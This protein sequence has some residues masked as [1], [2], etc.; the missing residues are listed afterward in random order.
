M[1][2][3]ITLAVGVLLGVALPL[4][5]GFLIPPASIRDD[6]VAPSG[7]DEALLGPT[8]NPYNF[9]KTEKSPDGTTFR[10]TGTHATTT[11]PYAA[12]LGRNIAVSL[13]L[14]A[15]REPGQPPADVTLSLNGRPAAQFRAAQDFQVYTA[16]IDD[17]A[18]PNPALDPAH[19][20]I[21]IESTTFV[22]LRKQRD[23]GVAVDWIE[24]RPE[25]SL[26]QVVVEA[27]VWGLSIL[28]VLCVAGARLGNRWGAGAGLGLLATLLAMHLTYVP[29]GTSP[30]VESGLVGL[31]WL[32]GVWLAPRARPVWGLVPALL[33]LWLVA[34]GR[35]LGEWQ[36]DDA[37]ISY[38]YGW[39]LVHGNGLIYNP[40]ERVEGYTN[41]LWTLLSAASLRL[42]LVPSTVALT[43][44]IALSL[45]LVALTWRLGVRLS[46]RRY[47]WPAT[48]CS[49]LVIDTAI[50]SYGARGSGMES[51]LFAFLVM[52]AADLIYSENPARKESYILGGLAL[53]LATLTRPE[54]WLV[55]GL[56]IGVRLLQ[57]WKGKEAW[58]QATLYTLLPFLVVVLPYEVW[59]ISYYGFLFPNT[60]YA[61]TGASLALVRRGMEHFSF[62][63]GD[64]W[65]P[66]ALTVLGIVMCILRWRRSSVLA[67]LGAY[68]LL[69]T[70]YI[71]WL[72]G[73]HFPGWR[74]FVPI[75][76][77]ALLVAQETARR[78]I[79]LLPSGGLLRPIVTGFALLVTLV[80]IN[81]TLWLE[82]SKGFLAA[83]TRL[84]TAYVERWG[85]AGLWLK[86]NTTPGTWTAAKGAGAIAYYSERP[87]VDMFG[88]TDLH[89]G[90]LEI[91]DMGER[92]A[93]H[94]KTDPAY[95]LS[96]RPAYILAEW[97]DYFD[98]LEL[99]I[100]SNYKRQK[101]RSPT[102]VPTQWLVRQAEASAR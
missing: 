13:R 70:L 58:R 66:V 92:N 9:Y 17:Q 30:L 44:N 99:Q 51:M 15:F 63:A 49:L 74:F 47:I 72:G 41:F 8:N 83:T 95:V 64:H 5:L 46:G 40:G 77:P 7:I 11:F 102:G 75:I 4:V 68:V 98:P 33:C 62:F 81:N 61:K 3:R 37:Y 67:A 2:N 18:V 35:L 90:H 94:D 32:V 89:I 100:A 53:A 22:S 42:G 31:A 57:M 36:L 91:P 82:E 1:R 97:A 84:H 38:R 59:R 21:D 56:F 24:L 34:A 55:A 25:R 101:V 14:A 88:L 45:G 28:L 79:A 86:A 96:R 93:G 6:M 80:Y 43:G 12:N 73:D 85:S 69:Q 29:R 16:H 48:C 20:Q 39:N 10:W 50:L 23:Q 87:T 71:I 27:L 78:G 19:V 54:G 52:L 60:F 65:L 76:A 26:E